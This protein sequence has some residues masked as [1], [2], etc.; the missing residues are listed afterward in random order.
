M[1]SDNSKPFF[2]PNDFEIS[3]LDCRLLGFIS[4]NEKVLFLAVNSSPKAA[5]EVFLISP[6]HRFHKV[7][8]LGLLCQ[9]SN[10]PLAHSLLLLITGCL[11]IWPLY[12]V[13]WSLK[14]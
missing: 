2:Y 8:F 6:L 10:T 13:F 9:L 3:G 12:I 14:I 5:S 1:Y 7:R 4:G 11:T